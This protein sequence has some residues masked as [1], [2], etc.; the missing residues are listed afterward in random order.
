MH[1]GVRAL[2]CVCQRS[3]RISTAQEMPGDLELR[4]LSL[5]RGSSYQHPP[6]LPMKMLPRR[7]RH[8]VVRLRTDQLVPELEAPMDLSEDPLLAQPGE[9]LACARRCQ[10]HYVVERQ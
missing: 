3:Q 4:R 9:R 2:E 8:G 6:P 10:A 5:F 1:G 7:R